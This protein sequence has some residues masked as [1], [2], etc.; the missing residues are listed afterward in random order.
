VEEQAA[1]DADTL[2]H[3]P[4]AYLTADLSGMPGRRIGGG[5][6]RVNVRDCSWWSTRQWVGCYS[7][8]YSQVWLDLGAARPRVR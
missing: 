3:R 5:R 7:V 4:G 2:F 8:C 6:P 1:V